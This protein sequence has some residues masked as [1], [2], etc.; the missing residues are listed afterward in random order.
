MRLPLAFVALSISILIGCATHQEKLQAKYETDL[1][2]VKQPQSNIVISHVDNRG[3]VV[4]GDLVDKAGFNYQGI[5]S[6][7]AVPLDYFLSPQR[8]GWGACCQWVL[9][10]YP[11]YY[12]GH[13][14]CRANQGYNLMGVL[15]LARAPD[16][17][18]AENMALENCKTAI[19]QFA[20]QVGISP[21]QS[22]LRCKIQKFEWCE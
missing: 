2:S 15:G 9:G 20:S 18:Q 13:Q 14:Y 19:Q 11:N 22:E 16:R 17:E 7:L 6:V 10:Y 4:Q 3:E 21:S 12:C 8:E 5:A 1:C